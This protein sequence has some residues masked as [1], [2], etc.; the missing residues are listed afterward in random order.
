MRKRYEKL[1]LIEIFEKKE[2]INMT[3]FDKECLK[4]IEIFSSSASEPENS[5]LQNKDL[6]YS[7]MQI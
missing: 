3:L 6:D 2:E 5:Q 4:W 7:L 1:Y